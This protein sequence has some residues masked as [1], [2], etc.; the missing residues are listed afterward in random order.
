MLQ[1]Q[2]LQQG[3]P[4]TTGPSMITSPKR[5]TIAIP[6]DVANQTTANSLLDHEIGQLLQLGSN[7]ALS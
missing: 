7:S 5:H 3:I 6:S 4:L 2:Q 1:L